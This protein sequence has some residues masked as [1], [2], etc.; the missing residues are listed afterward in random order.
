MRSRTLLNYAARIALVLAVFW[1]ASNVYRALVVTLAVEAAR[2]GPINLATNLTLV[3]PVWM[4][5]VVANAV[6]A[7]RLR[8]DVRR[9]FVQALVAIAVLS[10]GLLFGSIPLM[11]IAPKL[12]FTALMTT[13]GAAFPLQAILMAVGVMRL[14]APRD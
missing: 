10:V 3:A 6:I 5:C 9:P 1:L 8:A 4:T 11:R 12:G 2:V 13:G 7:A 14:S